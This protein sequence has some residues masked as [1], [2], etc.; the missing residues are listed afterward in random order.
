MS[1]IH[2]PFLIHSARHRISSVIRPSATE[3]SSARHR[4]SPIIRPAI[5]PSVTGNSSICRRICRIIR[6]AI[7]PSATGNR[8]VCHLFALLAHFLALPIA[9]SLALA[10]QRVTLTDEDNPPSSSTPTVTYREEVLLAT[11]DTARF[12][13]SGTE[14]SN[15]RL[16]LYPTPSYFI[17]DPRYRLPT[18]LEVYCVLNQAAIPNGYWQ[19]RQRILCYDTP[20]DFG[21]KI[22]SAYFGTDMY[23]TYIPNGTVIRAG[24]KTKYCILPIRTEQRTHDNS[25]LHITIN[26]EWEK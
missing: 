16:N 12:Y 2:P 14:I 23:Y 22:G 7:R 20:R 3:N 26:D 21:I 13:L 1:T 9:C 18:K 15:I 25:S 4:I 6:P 5:C 19:S 11:N 17:K 24:M 8:S 10:C